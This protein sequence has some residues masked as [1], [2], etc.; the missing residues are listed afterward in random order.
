MQS[1][2]TQNKFPLS[3]QLQ[4]SKFERR[5]SNFSKYQK[6]WDKYEDNVEKHFMKK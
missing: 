3:L 4:E 2:A 5:L 1:P 6:L